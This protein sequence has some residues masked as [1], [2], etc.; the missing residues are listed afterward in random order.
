MVIDGE[1]N[2]HGEDAM[3]VLRQAGYARCRTWDYAPVVRTSLT[4][5]QRVTGPYNTFGELIQLQQVPI[6]H[7][8]ATYR[9]GEAFDLALGFRALKTPPIDYSVGLYVRS[10]EG[11]AAGQQDGPP[12]NSRTSLWQPGE[13]FCDVHHLTAPQTPGTYS[14]QVALYD[15]Q[16]NQRLPVPGVP[17]GAIVLYTFKVE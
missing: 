6:N 12:A 10:A 3:R 4:E 1:P 2:R 14:V 8:P 17:D 13:T 11:K 16:T 5:W 9:P 7:T 15:W